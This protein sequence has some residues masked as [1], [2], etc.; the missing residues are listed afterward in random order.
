[1]LSLS[2]RC[3]GRRLTLMLISLGAGTRGQL[4]A[5][6]NLALVEEVGLL[7]LHVGKRWSRRRTLMALVQ[8]GCG[9]EGP[10]SGGRRGEGVRLLRDPAGK[11][12]G[13]RD[14]K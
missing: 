8:E 11:H 1:M 10:D 14:V 2:R 9:G 7:R 5:E 4:L 6:F 12:G 13:R 3:S